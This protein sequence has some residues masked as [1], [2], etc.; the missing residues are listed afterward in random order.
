MRKFCIQ[1]L[2]KLSNICCSFYIEVVEV[3]PTLGWA[4]EKN[5]WSGVWLHL[6]K[7]TKLSHVIT[8]VAGRARVIASQSQT[9]ILLSTS[10]LINFH[11]FALVPWAVVSDKMSEPQI[12]GCDMIWVVLACMIWSMI[13]PH[14]MDH[15]RTN[16]QPTKYDIFFVI[17]MCRMDRM[18]QHK[19]QGRPVTTSLPS[20]L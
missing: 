19:H 7:D 13:I 6:K 14:S 8:L 3:S 17:K 9:G 18:H 11:T 20:L 5:Q 12:S 16:Q 4:V 15:Y 1:E 10:N 2:L